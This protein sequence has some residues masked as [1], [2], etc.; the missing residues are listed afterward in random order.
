MSATGYAPTNPVRPVG[1]PSITRQSLMRSDEPWQTLC[2]AGGGESW[3]P[4]LPLSI[5]AI[6]AADN[7]L[8]S[9][10]NAATA[11]NRLVKT[12]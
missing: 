4:A 9:A 2:D 5:R 3:K 12:R 10:V 7:G 11:C 6:F 1:P 8:S